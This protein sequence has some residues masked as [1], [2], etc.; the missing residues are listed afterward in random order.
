MPLSIAKP[1]EQ[2]SVSSE[3]K[4]LTTNLNAC[5]YSAH[6]FLAATFHVQCFIFNDYSQAPW[7]IAENLKKKSLTCCVFQVPE[8]KTALG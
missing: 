7:K 3:H 4:S 1:S 2:L 8:L 6:M 5:Q